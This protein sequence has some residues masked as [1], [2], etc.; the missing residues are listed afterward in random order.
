MKKL[1]MI[2]LV[3]LMVTM[4]I[5]VDLLL[6][7]LGNLVPEMNDGLGIHSPL[8][9]LFFGDDHWSLARF[10][11]GFVISSFITLAV[12]AENVVLAI[13]EMKKCFRKRT[14]VG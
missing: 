9:T 6:N 14:P 10:Y 4:V 5:S 3:A 2:S 13:V 1:R 12:L 7:F 11:H 8:G